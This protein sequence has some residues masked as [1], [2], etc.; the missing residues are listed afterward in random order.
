MWAAYGRAEQRY[1]RFFALSRLVG[2]E[3][4]AGSASRPSFRAVCKIFEP[5]PTSA[6]GPLDPFAKPPVNDRYLRK[7]EVPRSM[8]QGT[9]CPSPDRDCLQ[10][11]SIQQDNVPVVVAHDSRG[12]PMLQNLIHALVRRSYELR[13][14]LMGQAQLELQTD[15]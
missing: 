7:A 5:T 11:G 12:I 1:S 3:I 4:Q 13:Q 9:D 6:S 8:A 14:D 10:F 2:L 15:V